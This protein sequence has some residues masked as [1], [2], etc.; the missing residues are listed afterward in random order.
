MS[1]QVGAV[2]QEGE[3][4]GE[5]ESVPSTIA[6][7]I[8]SQMQSLIT[9]MKLMVW[10]VAA[11]LVVGVMYLMK[12]GFSGTNILVCVFTHGCMNLYLCTLS[13]FINAMTCFH[14]WV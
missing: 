12:L 5:A 7:Q 3:A 2:E 11:L 10:V 14:N 4:E 9:I 13:T 6:H 1:V 8:E